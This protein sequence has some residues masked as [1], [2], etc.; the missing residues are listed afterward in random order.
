MPSCWPQAYT[1]CI[2]RVEL[3]YMRRNRHI[4]SS[5]QPAAVVRISFHLAAR[6]NTIIYSAQR[7]I[8][9]V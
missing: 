5:M 8:F 7:R 9:I 4:T 3:F 1:A 6:T 2:H